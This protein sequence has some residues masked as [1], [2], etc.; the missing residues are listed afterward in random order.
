MDWWK[1]NPIAYAET[2]TNVVDTKIAI[3]QYYDWLMT[4]KKDYE[5]IFVAYPIAFD[6][7][8]CFWYLMKF[9]GESPFGH[10]G[11]EIRSYAMAMF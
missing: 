11:I 9:K 6:F 10:N 3:E 1:I 2:Q 7:M 8:W 4:L 5:I